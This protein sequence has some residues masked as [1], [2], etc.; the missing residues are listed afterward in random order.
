M[1]LVTGG[2][3]YIGA[4]VVRH[5]RATERSVSVLDDLSTGDAARLPDDVELHVGR[6]DDRDFVRAALVGV[7][8][9]IHLAARKD[10]AESVAR[11]IWYQQENVT[12]L[13]VLL[14][15]MHEGGVG[16]IVFSSSA[17]VY[18]E[19]LGRRIDE[20]ARCEPLNPYGRTKLAGEWLIADQCAATGLGATALR[21]FN[22]A[23]CDEPALA[24]RSGNNLIPLVLAGLM[25]GQEPRVFGRDYPTPDG[26]CVRDFIHVGDLAEAHVVAVQE[27]ESR[28]GQAHM[29]VFNVGTGSGYS[30][31]EVL[32]SVSRV[33]G[34]PI[35]PVWDPRRP[36]DPAQVVAD[37]TLIGDRLD[38]HA[39][40]D[41]DAMVRSSWEGMLAPV[42][43]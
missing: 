4:H 36:G 34:R 20:S 27:L 2:A 8:G 19:P 15:S 17:A 39:Q 5:I 9:V 21:Y 41:L 7:E 33:T 30:V 38:W 37:P 29:E 42:K 13:A 1:W 6:I 35:S 11:P 23:G 22:V 16:R 24:E 40:H 18:G 12:G 14:E 25:A 26:T 43:E 28:E 10:V 32:Q 31:L 3:G